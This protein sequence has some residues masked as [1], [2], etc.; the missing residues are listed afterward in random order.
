LNDAARSF[1]QVAELSK[2]FTV[3]KRDPRRFFGRSERVGIRAVD[4]VSMRVQRG[5]TFAIVGESGSGKSTLANV[6]ARVAKP[7]AGRLMLDGDDITDI[8]GAQ[9]RALRQRIQM[10]FQDPSSSLNPRQTIEDIVGLPLRL[11]GKGDRKTRRARV[12]ELLEAVHLPGE[13]LH[14]MPGSLSGGQKQRVSIARALALRPELLILDE[15]TSALDVSV[16]ARI[17]TLLTDL[18]REQNLTYIVITHDLGVVRAIADR[19]AV[20]YLGRIV[21]TGTVDQIMSRPMH[22]YTR[23]LLSA[24][25]VVR[26]SDRALVTATAVLDGEI[27]SLMNPPSHCAFYSRCPQ[28][29]ARCRTEAPPELT[30]LAEGRAVRCHLHAPAPRQDSA[31]AL[32]T[33]PAGAQP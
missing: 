15:P 25:P 24:I 7:S 6:M 21:E 1:F 33:I 14:R 4:T 18:K 3:D 20:M 23:T 29:E 30:Q 9:L 22:P 17:L 31:D 26:E 12:I 16:Q 2:I 28:R 27:P 19:I 13:A 5:E 8:D 32:A 10:V 11:H